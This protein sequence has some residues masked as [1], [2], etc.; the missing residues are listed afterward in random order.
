M[1][2]GIIVKLCSS[3]ILISI[4]DVGDSEVTLGFSIVI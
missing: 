3:R 1:I 4:H 2:W